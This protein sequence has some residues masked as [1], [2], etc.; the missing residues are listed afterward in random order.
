MK[1]LNA[2]PAKE[3]YC[4]KCHSFVPSTLVYTVPSEECK[5]VSD[6][7]SYV[8]LDCAMCGETLGRVIGGDPISPQGLFI[9]PLASQEEIGAVME[10]AR[11]AVPSLAI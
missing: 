6:Y 8:F 4:P 2:F 7:Q 3:R 10:A 1:S 9:E 5:E 11:K